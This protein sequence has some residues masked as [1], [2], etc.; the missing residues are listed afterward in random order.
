MFENLTNKELNDLTQNLEVKYQ[1]MLK[2][3]KKVAS[4]LDSIYEQ[5]V[6]VQKELSKRKNK[7]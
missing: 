2:L 6:E 7:N 5:Y 3:V 4:E 1:K